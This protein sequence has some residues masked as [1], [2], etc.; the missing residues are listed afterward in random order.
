MKYFVE[1]WEVFRGSHVRISWKSYEAF[2]GILLES[3]EAFLGKN[4]KQS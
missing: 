1:P 3:Y 2:V 4:L